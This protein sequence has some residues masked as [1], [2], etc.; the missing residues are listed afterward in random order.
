LARIK[1]GVDD[2]LYLGNLEAKRDWGYAKDY[3]EGMWLMLQQD[4]PDD[5]VLATGETHTVREFVE[6]SAKLLGFDLKWRGSELEEEGIDAK[7]GKVIVKI[8]PTY[9]RPS[10]VDLLIGD[11]TKAK[12][13]LGWKPKVTFEGLAKLMVDADLKEERKNVA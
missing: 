5:Y 13:K 11:Y 8:D 9:F 10:E 6:V 4:E 7:S 3:I 12:T 2:I 1:L